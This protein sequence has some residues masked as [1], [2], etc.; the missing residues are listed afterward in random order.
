MALKKPAASSGAPEWVVTYGDLMSLLLCFFVLLAAM[1]NFDDD[2]QM[3]MTAM[4]SIREALGAPGQRGWMP[5]NSVDFKS[6]LLMLQTLQLPPM[7]ANYGYSDQASSIGKQ[8]KVRKIRDG[9]EVTIGGRIGFEPNASQPGPVA[10]ALLDQIAEK[11]RGYRNRVEI[12][13]H[14]FA[15]PEDAGSHNDAIELSFARARAVRDRL[16]A[17]GVEPERLRLVAVGPFE[18]VVKEAVSETQR[19]ENRRVEILVMQSTIEDY[20]KFSQSGATSQPAE[21]DGAATPAAANPAA[22]MQP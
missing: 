12:R 13:G 11:I 15:E 2:E 4:E 14:T 16:I 3:M 17:K 7:P 20:R 10:L 22:T 18:P 8:Y 6:L 21:S 5:D 1:A 19:A 9:L